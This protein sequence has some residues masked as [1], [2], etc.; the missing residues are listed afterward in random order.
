MTPNLRDQTTAEGGLF[1]ENGSGDE[2]LSGKWAVCSLGIV[3]QFPPIHN[4][5]RDGC[6]CNLSAQGEGFPGLGSVPGLEIET[7]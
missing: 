3:S 5:T 1:S 6:G 2:P 7:A 4:G